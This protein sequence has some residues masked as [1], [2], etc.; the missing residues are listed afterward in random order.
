MAGNR[1]RIAL[2]LLP[3]LLVIVGLFGGSLAYTL[4]QSLGWQPVIGRTSLDLRSYAEVLF[5]ARHAPAF[6]SGLLFSLWISA[7]STGLSAM[8]AVAS[9]LLLRRTFSGR[10][11][12]TYLFQ[13]SLPIPHLVAAVGMLFL[14]SQSGLLSRLGASVGLLGSPAG[15]PILVRDPLGIGVILA[16]LWKEVPF[17]G[18]ILLA[19]LQ[20]LGQDHEEAARTLGANRWQRFRLVTLPLIGPSLAASSIIVF[21]FVFGAYEI[22]GV[23]GV[24]Y[25]RA[26]PVLAYQL[27]LSP[28][29]NDRS[30]A[31]ALSMVIS[32]IVIGLVA[33]YITLDRRA[34]ARVRGVG[35]GE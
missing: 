2:L 19:T 22:P 24:R 30:T 25:P 23:L 7:A 15:F 26:L 35:G 16:Y 20:S 5:G 32:F 18:L 34:K 17:M 29:L 4:L 10:R 3:A 11:L 27:F 1:R 31:T 28:D 9:A 8:L 6:W 33:G 21:S 13:F 12:A 14:F